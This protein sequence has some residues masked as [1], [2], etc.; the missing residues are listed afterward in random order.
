[1]R[2]RLQ[3]MDNLKPFLSTWTYDCVSKTPCGSSQS[4]TFNP[5]FE[6][7]WWGKKWRGYHTPVKI[8]QGVWIKL[9]AQVVSLHLVVTSQW[10]QS[11]CRRACSRTRL[12]R[13]K[14]CDGIV[15]LNFVGCTLASS[16][17]ISLIILAPEWCLKK[18]KLRAVLGKHVWQGVHCR[19]QDV[20]KN[21]DIRLISSQSEVNCRRQTKESYLLKLA[22][23][24]VIVR[25]QQGHGKY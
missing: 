18:K 15:T 2:L 5:P 16:F 12:K 9:Q 25:Q 21:R 8:K 1:M 13:N 19:W 11:P 23:Q 20:T 14:E 24:S 3:I 6:A 7:A 22:K 17:C 10:E 4:N